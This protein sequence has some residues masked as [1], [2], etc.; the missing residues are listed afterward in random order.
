MIEKGQFYRSSRRL[1]KKSWCPSSSTSIRLKSLRVTSSPSSLAT[2]IISF[3]KLYSRIVF[4]V[5]LYH[6]FHS[7]A[8]KYG[9]ELCRRYLSKVEEPLGYILCVLHLSYCYLI[10]LVHDS[11]PLT[12]RHWTCYICS[13]SLLIAPLSY[14]L[15]LRAFIYSHLFYS[16]FISFL[17]SQRP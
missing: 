14:S 13:V 10:Q 3:V 1:V 2:I 7:L 8:D 15:G 11:K 4:H 12:P 6:L 17:A 16:T 9:V 5:T